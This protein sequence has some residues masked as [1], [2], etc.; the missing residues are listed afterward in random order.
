M[1]LLVSCGPSVKVKIQGTKEGVSVT[2]N[3][4]ASDSSGVHIQVNPTVQ[5]VPNDGTNK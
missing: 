4:H 1:L 3:Q 2:T 5:I